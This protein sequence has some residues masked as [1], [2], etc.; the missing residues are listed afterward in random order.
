VGAFAAGAL[1]LAVAG[2][3]LARP[4]EIALQ[5][6]PDGP[7][8]VRLGR[9][10]GAPTGGGAFAFEA[11]P[12]GPI[13]ARVALGEGCSAE[14]CPGPDCSACCSGLEREVSGGGG[15]S[16]ARL[17]LAPPPA[18]PDGPRLVAL[19]VAGPEAPLSARLPGGDRA[20]G[21]AGAPLVLGPL[22]P[23]AHRLLLTAGECPDP[24]APCADEGTCPAGCSAAEREVVVT[25]GE[26]P[27][28]VEVALPAPAAPGGWWVPPGTP[29]ALVVRAEG[30]RALSWDYREIASG[31]MVMGLP[32]GA[33]RRVSPGS[34]AISAPGCDARV[35]VQPGRTTAVVCGPGGAR[36]EIR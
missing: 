12:R 15:L 31:R 22:A 35:E 21:E 8:S 4:V 26:G 13:T 20:E 36:V 1:A 32:S 18:P 33:A 6:A 16:T 34:Y 25:C 2:A 3:G 11:I 30:G 5:P 17:R 10:E 14:A 23:G 27:Q 9:V 29:G 28:P 24:P 19:S 7:A